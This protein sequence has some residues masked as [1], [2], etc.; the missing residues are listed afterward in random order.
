LVS[1]PGKLRPRERIRAAL[2]H[3]TPDR[4]PLDIGG[5]DITG[6]HVST[7]LKLRAALGLPTTTPKAYDT[8]QMLAEFEDDLRRAIGVD[9]IGLALPYTVFGYRNEGWK[10]FR[11]P[12]GTD[13]LVS[14]NFVADALP[15]GSLVQFPQA[16]R[17]CLPSGRMARDGFYFDLL[18]RQPAFSEESLDACRW[19]DET[20]RLCRDED[21]RYLEEQS[22]YLSANTDYAVVADLNPAGFGGFVALVA[23]HVRRP[24]GIRNPE[25][26]WMSYLG[27][28]SHIQDIFSYQSELQMK[29]LKMYRQALGDRIDV[30]IMCKTDFG[31]QNGP[32]I[33]PEIYRDLFKPLHRKMNDWVHENT[34]WKTFF[35]TCGDVSL[36]LPDFVEAGLDVLNPV[37]ISAS[38]MDPAHLK[39]AYGDKLVFWGGGVSTQTTLAFGTREQVEEEVSRNLEIFG[40]GGGFVFAPDQ[41]VQPAV[42]IENLVAVLETLNTKRAR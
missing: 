18:Y 27:R 36:L 2:E 5:T 9:V 28:K 33:A 40:N 26:F 31:M 13:A 17:T 37:Q 1:S 32:I 16:D 25:E 24:T 22:R 20:Y 34:N 41:N 39:D 42:P 4:V 14:R 29:N 8:F 6:I 38:N 23:P 10:P 15:D 21:L 35:H 12:D 3:R 7:Y 11:M 30:I 19:V